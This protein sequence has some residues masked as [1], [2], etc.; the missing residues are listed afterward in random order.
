MT[1]TSLP[2]KDSLIAKQNGISSVWE[3]VRN[4]PPT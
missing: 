3:D 4:P 1:S 2:P